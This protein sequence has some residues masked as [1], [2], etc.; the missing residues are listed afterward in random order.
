M[1]Q[2]SDDSKDPRPSSGQAATGASYVAGQLARA[3][4]AAATHENVGLRQKAAARVRSLL[5][6]LDHIGSGKAQVGE[7]QPYAE[8]PTWVTPEVLR[9]GFASGQP[10]AGGDWQAHEVALAERLGLVVASTRTALNGHYLDPI[11]LAEL[12]ERL[13]SRQY[14]VDL[15]EEGAL[16]AIRWLIAHGAPTT[17]A[18]VLDQI[19]P[20]F[21]RLRF[22]PRPAEASLPDPLVGLEAPVL[23]RSAHALAETLAQKRPSDEVEAM[24]EHYEV[25]APLTDALV[26]LLLETVDGPPPQFDG[27]GPTRHITG[28]LPFA[29]FPDDFE[30]RRT[31]LLATVAAARARHRRCQRVHRPKEVLGQLTATLTAWPG[32]DPDGRSR[33]AARTRLRLAGFV[34]AHGAPGSERHRALRATQLAGPSHARLAHVLAERL[35]ALAEPGEALGSLGVAAAAR[36]ITHAEQ[37]ETVRAGAHLPRHLLD[38]L[39]TV[40]ES[41]LDKLVAARVVRSGEALAA[42]LPQLTG[43]VLATRFSQADARALYAASYRAFRRRRSLLLLWLQH[44]VQF[45]ELPWIAA[46]EASADADPQPAASDLLRRFSAFA[47]GAFPATITPNKLVSELTALT[48]VARPPMAVEREASADAAP[49]LPLVEELAA[50]IFMGTFSAKYVRAAAIAIRHL[51]SLPGGALYSRYYGIDA[52]RVLAMTKIEERW[53]TKVCPDFDGYCLELAALPP[54]GSSIARN[55][56]V[57]EQAA[58]LTTHNLGVLV[59]VLQLQPLLNDRWSDLAGQAFGAVLDRL[60]RRVIPE[61]VPRHQRK[62]ASK[63]LAFGWRQM[64]FFLSCLSPSAQVAFTATC[65]ERLDTRSA[66]VRERFAPVLA[67]LERTVAGEQLPRAAS[68]DEVDGC[69]RLL[70]WSIGTPFLMRAAREAD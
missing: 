19:E 49:W 57:I 23:A 35:Q 5:R 27:E 47:I 10:A 21:D 69:R 65:R 24:R 33:A 43:P 42:L 30:A 44:Q 45:A 4:R 32:L 46:L 62:R 40:Q 37:R 39:S 1:T 41:S 6:L 63:T 20:F 70:G 12:A 68:H 18:A 54:G 8:L 9:G 2:P 22:Y 15:P 28:G 14:R 31:E 59:D 50:D 52:E 51:A 3:L 34:T 56:A 25:W 58:I 7:R 53:G 64:I 16:L 55:G 29:R 36:P 60:E 66:A 38:R 67:G 48:K 61:S 13:A 17:A 26:A 11:G